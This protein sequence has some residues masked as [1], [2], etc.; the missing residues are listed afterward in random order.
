MKYISKIHEHD[1]IRHLS[2]FYFVE[3]AMTIHTSLP[4]QRLYA[5]LLACFFWFCLTPS[6][7]QADLLS[8]FTNNA[9]TVQN[10]SCNFTQDKQLAFLPQPLHSEG[11]M[12]FERDR[13]GAPAL[14]WEYVLPAPSGLWHAL[15]KNWLW[16]GDKSTLHRASR[17]EDQALRAILQHILFWFTLQPNRL[18]EQYAIAED[19]TDAC[20]VF[21]PRNNHFF[22]RLRVCLG[23]DLHSLRSMHITEQNGDSTFLTFTLPAIDEAPLNAFPDGTPLP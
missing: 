13:G 16:V 7:T 15:G 1:K 9:V 3:H 2:F 6:S 4:P 5:S 22:T 14:L 10:L 11:H 18:H 23:K 12:V 17:E 19:T 20:M 21:T 8:Q